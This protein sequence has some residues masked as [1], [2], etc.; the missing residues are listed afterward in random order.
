MPEGHE[1]LDDDEKH[2]ARLGYV[3]ELQRSWSGFS[4][5]AISFSIISILAGCFTSFG[6]GWNNGG[7]AAIA[8]GWP[9]VSAFILITGLCLSEL[10]S[11]YPTS[12]GIY[13][14]AAKLGGP[15]AGFYTGWLNLIG[16][17]AILASV[18]YGCATFLD[19]TLGTFS[20]SWLAG[21]SLTRTFVIFVI[22]LAVSATIN[23]LSSHLLAVINNV[24]VW[25]H[26]AGAVAVVA[27]L[28]LIPEQHA[29]VSDVFAQTINNSGIFDGEK[30]IGWLLFVLPISAILTQYTIT[31]YDASAHLSEET[32]SAADGAAKGIWR[33]IFYSAIGGWIL[34]LTFL[35][36]VQDADEV[37]AGGGAV[38][39]IFNQAM[40][41]TWVAIVLL[42]S[43]AGQFFCTTACQTSASRMLFAFS[44]DR[45][46]PGHQLWSKV[47]A[48]RVP[49]NAVVV[50]AVVAAVITLPALVEV[51]VNG[52]PVPVAFFAVVSIGVV[53]LYL[54]FAVPIYYRWKL[55]DRF[56]VGRW[57]L[58]GHHRWMAPVAIAEIVLTS[59]IAMFPTSL[60]GMPWDPSFA[61]KFV[62]YTPLLVG[63]VLI[64]L[65]I[66]WHVSV[67]KWF[68]GPIKQI[69]ESDGQ[70][71]GVS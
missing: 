6:L 56:E 22:I 41:S 45:A 53:G 44:R 38:V 11:A 5:F 55:G 18:S 20:E 12:G 29:S 24:S 51:D 69:D 42:I 48:K 1:H 63:G 60:G 52:A 66:Y 58:R 13:W 39:T 54:C 70:L 16:L 21:Y 64:L 49:A 47:S 8:W 57:N 19:L 7:P 23:I 67:K 17:V 46:V 68:T 31:G 3:Q 25:W 14:W 36:A 35:F 34:L 37:S 4:N 43:T 9:I 61:W 15:K 30:G 2:L 50:T 62:N 71:E 26:V 10:V 27:I 32:R 65:F 40:D 59:M 33:S 28:W